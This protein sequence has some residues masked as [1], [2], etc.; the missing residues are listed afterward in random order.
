MHRALPALLLALA[1]TLPAGFGCGSDDEAST[2]AAPA[3]PDPILIGVPVSRAYLYGWAAER[4]IVL[5]V[6]EINAAGGVDV[7]GVERK[8]AYEVI[9]TRDLEPGVPL[10]DAIK[11]VEKLILQKR[12]DFLVGGPV[13]SEAAMAVMDLLSR[14]Q[15]VSII[16][17]GVLSPAY[18][19]AVA[20]NYDAYKYCF[21]NTSEVITLGKDLMTVLGGL[22]TDHGLSRVAIMVQDV[23]HAR[24]AGEF[25][26][27]LLKDGGFEVVGHEIYPTG[28]TDFAPGLL[29]SGRA[30]AQIIFIWMDMPET[31]NLLR[32]WK[33]LRLASLPVGFMSAAEQPGFWDASDGSA[34]YTVVDLINAGN[35]A[36]NLTEWTPRFVAAY[37]QRWGL[38]PEGY[39]ASSSYMAV[40]S[41]KD[42]VE[43]AG[44]TDA[45]AVVTALEAIDL[46][47]VYG[48]VRFDPKTHQV[49]ASTD[50][51][52][53][54][55][56]SVFQWQDGERVT[57][58]P[59]AAAV[60][61]LKLPP[62]MEE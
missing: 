13:R 52:E 27:G 59:P 43:R 16:T 41:L 19:K 50:P 58:W 44:T 35:A 57:V 38:P 10:D 4:G 55:V 20:E 49:I 3:E 61:T 42:A 21:R 39:G 22:R 60:G 48:R 1:L 51:N 25:V 62:W 6:E 23:A 46:M 11:A 30:K 37:E 54:V 31:S 32:Q 29:A 24:R 2:A 26:E 33:S 53:G 56:G 17:T 8:L 40:Y 9:D 12:V 7:G 45:E 15:R 14:H 18:H 47:G 28:T 36:S 34:E 5:A